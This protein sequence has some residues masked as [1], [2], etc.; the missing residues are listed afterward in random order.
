MSHGAIRWCNAVCNTHSN[1]T[2][3]LFG[4]DYLGTFAVSKMASSVFVWSK[5]KTDIRD[6]SEYIIQK[7]PFFLKF[8]EILYLYSKNTFLPFT[9]YPV[10]TVFLFKEA[11]YFSVYMP[12]VYVDDL[13]LFT[14]HSEI[15][16]TRDCTCIVFNIK[17][18]GFKFLQIIFFS[19]CM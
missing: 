11:A 5:N 9:L 6:G 12:F 3:G 17:F 1:I 13:L 19:W 7:W 14:C 18:Y 10:Y 4:L 2:T 16:L 15:L 8:H